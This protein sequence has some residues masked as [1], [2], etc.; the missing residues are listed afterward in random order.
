MEAWYICRYGYLLMK[1]SGFCF[2]LFFGNIYLY[3]F[4][5]RERERHFPSSGSLRKCSGQ[6]PADPG[7]SH[8]PVTLAW[9]HCGFQDPSTGTICC[10]TPGSLAGSR[11]RIRHG[12]RGLP[13]SHAA[14]LC[15][16]TRENSWRNGVRQFGE[17]R[18]DLEEPRLEMKKCD[19]NTCTLAL[20]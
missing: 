1:W 2:V 17:T 19:V 6:A 10:S 4:E 16:T 13:A 15:A 11:I 9:S 7:Q 14:S 3:L 12:A 18:V 8:K 20:W 5:R